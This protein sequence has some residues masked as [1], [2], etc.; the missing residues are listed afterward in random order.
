LNQI[1]EIINR[2]LDLATRGGF[3][4]NDENDRQVIAERCAKR[5]VGASLEQ[6]ADLLGGSVEVDNEGQAIIY[7]DIN[8]ENKDKESTNWSL[9][10]NIDEYN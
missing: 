2:T 1:A 3:D 6:L 8:M 7:T 5:L 4:F 10:E 9:V